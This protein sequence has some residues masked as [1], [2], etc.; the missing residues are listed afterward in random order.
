MSN[1]QSVT[2]SNTTAAGTGD[3]IWYTSTTPYSSQNIMVDDITPYNWSISSIIDE[4]ITP[5]E[6]KEM[7]IL[8]LRCIKEKIELDDVDKI[9]NDISVLKAIDV[10][11]AFRDLLEKKDEVFFD[12]IEDDI[13]E[14][15][16]LV[17]V[18]KLA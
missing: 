12:D 14:E 7:L 9:L 5:D 11:S 10:I 13:I 18:K 4:K 8:L 3:T 6:L 1:Y 16:E 17:T 2:M 15:I